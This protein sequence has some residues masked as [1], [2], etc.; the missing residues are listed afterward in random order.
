MSKKP[1]QIVRGMWD[2]IGRGFAE[3]PHLPFIFKNYVDLIGQDNFEPTLRDKNTPAIFF[4]CSFGKL[5]IAAPQFI[6]LA[7][8][9]IWIYRAPNNPYVEAIL[10][11]CRSMT[12]VANIQNLRLECVRC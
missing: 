1:K 9:S 4:G 8:M 3:Y 7:L 12:D 2:N 5:E 10:Q 11:R 6:K